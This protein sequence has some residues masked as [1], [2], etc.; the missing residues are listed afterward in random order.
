[1]KFLLILLVSLSGTYCY[2]PYGKDSYLFN[3]FLRNILSR[4]HNKSPGDNGGGDVSYLDLTDGAA[5][6][7]RALGG[8][9]DMEEEP[10]FDY[11]SNGELNLLPSIRDQEYLQHSSLWGNQYVSGG[12]GEGNQMLRPDGMRNK[13]EV[14]TDSTLPAYCN[15]PNPCPIGYNEDHG[16]IVDFE[17]SASF[18]RRYQA[19]QDCMCDNEHMFECPSGVNME[20]PIDLEELNFN[21]FLEQSLKLNGMQHKNMV[22]KKFHNK[23]MNNANPYLS[24]ERL[25]VAAKKGI[26]VFEA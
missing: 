15:P 6:D 7:G 10:P 18:S 26:N 13:Q 21:R 4:I 11:D 5:L 19:S 16:C 25:P 3:L 24:G 1:M 12:A 9:G 23:E 8:G 22:A 14:K 17:N 20:D 2:I